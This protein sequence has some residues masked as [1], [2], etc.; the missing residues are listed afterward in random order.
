MD[1]PCQKVDHKNTVCCIC[2]SS[3]TH[4]MP[5]GD[6]LWVK[7]RDKE[8]NWDEKS[9]RYYKCHYKIGKPKTP[10]DYFDGRI[11]CVCRSDNT[12]M[13]EKSPKWY[14]CKCGKIECTG[15][16]CKGCWT[17]DY[18]RI[19]RKYTS[20][21]QLA[22]KPLANYRTGNLSRFTEVGKGVI[23]QWIIAKTLNIKDLNIENSNFR[24][25]VDISEHPI[26]GRI[27]A[28]IHTKK[29]GQWSIKA[30]IKNDFDSLIILC[31]DKYKLWKNVERVYIIFKDKIDW[32]TGMTIT[33]DP[34]YG[35]KYEKYR[36]DK[37][38]YNDT[39]RSVDIPTFFSPFDLWKGKYEK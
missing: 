20:H 32:I 25:P 39:Y 16:M 13:V 2:E 21:Y 3:K 22:L 30:S 28:K 24:Q 18:Y 9:Y 17:K 23:G 35:F 15:Y 31:M 37:N 36:I 19:K 27:E 4:I 29:Y 8:G 33:E 26:Y 14:T 1:M 34:S 38:P 7:N 6:L 12:Y 11:C 10:I 5:N